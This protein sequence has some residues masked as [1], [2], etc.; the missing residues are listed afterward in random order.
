LTNK[1]APLIKRVKQICKE[2]IA[3]ECGLSQDSVFGFFHYHPQFWH[4]HMHFKRNL[5]IFDNRFSVKNVLIKLGTP[6]YFQTAKLLVR[7]RISDIANQLSERPKE[8][9]KKQKAQIEQNFL[10]ESFSNLSISN[11]KTLL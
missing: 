6:N 1:D 7:C 10:E 4:L 5:N 2:K 9:I 3:K 11:K 8:N